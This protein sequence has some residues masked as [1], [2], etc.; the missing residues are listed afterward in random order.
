MALSRLIWR[1]AAVAVTRSALA[2]LPMRVAQ[3][4]LNASA[5]HSL[6]G[7]PVSSLVAITNFGSA[8]YCTAPDRLRSET[9]N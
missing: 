4:A 3:P 1:S 6:T 7:L 5:L 2:A 9:S 8:H